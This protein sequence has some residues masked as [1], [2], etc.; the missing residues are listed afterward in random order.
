MTVSTIVAQQRRRA[1]GTG[2]PGCPE[3]PFR[4][5]DPGRL[6]RLGRLEAD[7]MS[8]SL[9][10]LAGRQPELFDALVG[11]AEAYAGAESEPEPEPFCVTCGANAGIFWL[12]GTEW[13]HFRP[14]SGAGD[15]PQVYEPG[16]V[17]VI[18][19]RIDGAAIPPPA[20]APAP[21]I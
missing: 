4:H 11:E 16:H 1:P 17:P 7:V 21:V 10:I 8:V 2:A 20:A 19:W 5:A 18:G 14:G 3:S 13:H 15:G 9:A 12:L 6:F